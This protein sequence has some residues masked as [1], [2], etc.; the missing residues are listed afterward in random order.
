MSGVS[1]W[2]ESTK[3][4]GYMHYFFETGAETDNNASYSIMQMMKDPDIKDDACYAG[5][6]FIPKEGCPGVQA[7]DILAWHAGQDCKRA[8]RGEPIRKDFASLH[9]IPHTVIHLTRKKLFE[10]ADI[11]NSELKEAGLTKEMANKIETMARRTPKQ[12]K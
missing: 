7:A 3:F 5:H 2:I 11:I 8:L 12:R 9:E 4:K 6:S 10:H 1:G